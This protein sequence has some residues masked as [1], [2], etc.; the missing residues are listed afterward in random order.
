MTNNFDDFINI[1]KRDPRVRMKMNDMLNR[2]N[3]LPCNYQSKIGY[4]TLM[5]NVILKK[6]INIMATT[7]S[8]MDIELKIKISRIDY[9]EIKTNSQIFKRVW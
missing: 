9:L 8:D 2:Y 3:K 4:D 5:Q 6:F 1:I 7:I